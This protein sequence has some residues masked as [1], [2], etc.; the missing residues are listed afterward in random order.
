[1]SQECEAKL[2]GRNT[3]QAKVDA[4]NASLAS[5]TADYLSCLGPESQGRAALEAVAPEMD[6][7]SREMHETEYIHELIA[8]QLLRQESNQVVFQGIGDVAAGE[9]QRMQDEIAELKK[10]IRTERRRFLDAGPSVSP[11]VGG[12]YFTRVPDNKVLIAFLSCFGAFLLFVGLLVLMNQVPGTYFDAM[13]MSE[14]VKFVGIAW[15]VSL[16]VSWVAFYV[17]T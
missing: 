11:A 12:L 14:R 1:M 8:K 7:I 16:I 13:T 10:Q 15:V 4:A 3:A 2:V 6:R 5:A 9:I 17:F